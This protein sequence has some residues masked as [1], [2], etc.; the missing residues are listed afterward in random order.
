MII[1]IKINILKNLLIYTSSLTKDG[2]CQGM[3]FIVSFI[4]KITNFDEIKSY[5]FIKYIFPEIKGYFEQGFPLLKKN[6]NLFYKIFSKLYPTLDAHFTK[7]D[8][9]AQFWVGK[10]LQT[11]FTLSL[12]FDEL[13]YIWDLLLIK[14]FDFCILI[15]LAIINYL[16][17]YLREFLWE[18]IIAEKYSNHKYFD[19]YEEEK[20]YKTFIKNYKIEQNDNQIE[21][22]I[23]RTFPDISDSNDNKINGYN[24]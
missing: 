16:E 20:E 3:N 11:L 5:Y 12:P 21:K 2:Y 6:I 23:L 22:D 18:I 24:K 14:G 8:V 10:W 9:F 17:K 7:N 4:L 15:S 1:L 19:R 13:C